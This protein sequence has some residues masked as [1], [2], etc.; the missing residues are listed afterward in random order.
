MAEIPNTTFREKLI[1]G[2]SVP[3]QKPEVCVPSQYMERLEKEIY[4]WRD[5]VS[6]YSSLLDKREKIQK[7]IDDEQRKHI[8][9]LRKK[10]QFASTI[11]IDTSEIEKNS[12]DNRKKQ[13]SKVEGY[14]ASVQ[15]FVYKSFMSVTKF[16]LGVTQLGLG[17]ISSTLSKISDFTKGRFCD[18]IGNT[19]GKVFSFFS[20]KGKT[21]TG[22]ITNV[23]AQGWEVIKWV[24]GVGKKTL[25]W[26]WDKFV[27]LAKIGWNVLSTV[28]DFVTAPVNI[29]CDIFRES[30]L[31]I[32]T[33]PLGFVGMVAGFVFALSFLVKT[34]GPAIT[35][36]FKGFFKGA[37][38][39]IEKIVADIFTNGNVSLLEKGFED[40]SK[41]I[42]VW[43]GK[44]WTG[45][46]DYYD[47]HLGESIDWP[48]AKIKTVL[49]GE[50]NIFIKTWN[51]VI[52]IFDSIYDS[53]VIYEV[54]QA[55]R[56]LR[57]LGV[58]LKTGGDFDEAEQLIAD[59]DKKDENSETKNKIYSKMLDLAI[60]SKVSIELTQTYIANKNVE[61]KLLSSM[62]KKKANEVINEFKSSSMTIAG[63]DSSIQTDFI[64]SIIDRIII[65]DDTQLSELIDKSQS[66]LIDS[67]TKLIQL[68][69]IST[70]YGKPYKTSE[71]LKSLEAGNSLYI[72]DLRIDLAL[73]IRDKDEEISTKLMFIN[74]A[75]ESLQNR[76]QEEN[77]IS[78]M[79]TF[80][81]DT[82]QHQYGANPKD[83]YLQLHTEESF[84]NK[85]LSAIGI[86][87]KMIEKTT[88]SYGNQD[89]INALADAIIENDPN[90]DHIIPKAASGKVVMKPTTVLVGEGKDPEIIIPLN[91]NG[92]EF[93]HNSMDY[94]F[95][96]EPVEKQ[97]LQ[98]EKQ[99]VIRKQSKMLPKQDIK[100][101]DM[102]NISRGLMGM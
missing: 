66:A 37:W 79:R 63:L 45:I 7:G 95:I 58:V 85:R 46:V 87:Q 69:T 80:W 73:N 42:G 15:K 93:I 39:F 12:Q 96:E 9:F 33:S 6:T 70:T 62:L 43:L 47:K 1:Q 11:D 59:E 51:R 54:T 64:D 94:L 23:A 72:K 10:S 67:S 26:I 27:M 86:A 20:S 68:K 77:K 34:A 50:N 84:G 53:D 98:Q 83:I 41:Q 71:M 32:V 57:Y 92:M 75:W 36:F 48:Y 14:F 55:F 25:T 19:V 102:K 31:A 30:F 74:N 8:E 99:Q 4:A 3:N 56:F 24:Y 52:A 29:V 38:G 60:Q 35:T 89:E 22:F 82:V 28:W 16:A 17:A 78:K 44:T 90:I 76:A 61:K 81:E 40:K 13:E 65:S 91:K 101:Y 2:G 49:F 97:T 21:L 18:V 88:G 100:I 5:L